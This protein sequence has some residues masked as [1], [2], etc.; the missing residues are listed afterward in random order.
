MT[1]RE[2]VIRISDSILYNLYEFMILARRCT[3]Y[4][5]VGVSYLTT[6]A[7]LYTGPRHQSPT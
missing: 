2:R 3:I 6:G 7:A 1:V 5:C 4:L